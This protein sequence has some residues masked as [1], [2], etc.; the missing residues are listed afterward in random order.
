MDRPLFILDM[1]N[2]LFLCHRIPYPPNKGDKIRSYHILKHLA[3]RF[4]VYLGTFI[5]DPDDVQ[6]RLQ[7][8]DYCR[9]AHFVRIR[10]ALRQLLSLR[11]L[12]TGQ[13]LSLPYY[14][15]DAMRGWIRG[16]CARKRIEK[17]F[18]F[19]SSMAQFAAN[20]ACGD[21]RRVI[22]FVDVDSEKWGA[23]ARTTT[24]P[25]SWI[26]AREGVR[27]LEYEKHIARL[28]D[29]SIFVSTDE[30]AVFET[31]L[32][33]NNATV[34][35][36]TNGV[37]L[38]YFD[39][40]FVFD[41]P[42]SAT[43]A[44]LVFTGAMDYWANVDAVVWFANEIFPAIRDQVNTAEFCIVGGKPS[45]E[46]LSLANRAGITVTGAV[47]DVRP[48]IAHARCAVAPMRI[49]RGIQNKVL[50]AMAMGKAVIGTRA[51]YEGLADH[52]VYEELIVENPADWARVAVRLLRGDENWNEWATRAYVDAHHSWHSSLAMLDKL[53]N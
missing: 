38:D 25:K 20:G 44:T 2:L 43:A 9:E 26:Y 39:P 40:E 48:Y 49:A 12:L 10:P 47:P 4:H 41:N 42:Y 52:A 14:E 28:F 53:L 50:E 46:V 18:V 21:M 23:Y 36:M 19:S 15:S 45:R 8:N 6:Y 32:G 5:D 16:L 51:A 34:L 17:A 11:G 24:W 37:D 29:A 13:A 30:A 7:V 31:R 35:S 27:L 1:E 22:D 3:E 33:E